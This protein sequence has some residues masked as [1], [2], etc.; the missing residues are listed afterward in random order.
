MVAC[1]SSRHTGG[2]NYPSEDVTLDAVHQTT[3]LGESEACAHLQTNVHLRVREFPIYCCCVRD[4]GLF[5]Y[6]HV[7]LQMPLYL[8]KCVYVYLTN[9]SSC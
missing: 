4:K 6:K 2:L 3:L 9:I 5:C 7:S 1:A 8:D